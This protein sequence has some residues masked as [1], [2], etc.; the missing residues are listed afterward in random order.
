LAWVAA[1]LALRTKSGGRLALVAVGALA[2]WLAP[3]ALGRD[4]P[5]PERP[6][7]A[8][9][10]AAGPPR[11]GSF[12]WSL[13]VRIES[14]R[15]GGRLALLA[16]PAFVSLPAAPE[17]GQRFHLTGYLG[18]AP[19]VYND[20]SAELGPWRLRVKSAHFV[21]PLPAGWRGEWRGISRRLQ[22]KVGQVLGGVEGG[23][24]GALARAL[25]LGEAEALP[26]RVRRALRRFGVAH[27]VAVS[28]LHVTLLA[29]AAA[30]A[31]RLLPRPLG[32]TLPLAACLGYLAL[33]GPRPS[34]VRASAMVLI[35][36]AAIRSGRPPQSLHALGTVAVLLCLLDPRGLSDLGL[37]LTLAATAGILL[38]GLWL[39]SNRCLGRSVLGR[40]VVASLAAQIATWPFALPAFHLIAPISPVANL[41]A[42]PWAGV[43]LVLAVARCAGR[44]A[45]AVLDA[46]LGWALEAAASPFW[47]LAGLPAQLA[48]VRPV[49]CGPL[50]ATALA[51]VAVAAL[52][53]PRWAMAGATWWLVATLSRPAVPANPELRL[54]DVGQGEAILLT[55]RGRAVLIDGGGWAGGD[56]AAELLLPALARAGVRELAAIILTHPDLDHCAGLQGLV[57]Y[58]PVAEL[59]TPPGWPGRGCALELL[60]A[61]G[62]RLRPLWAGERFAVGRWEF[63]ALHPRAGARHGGNDRSLVLR[64][65]A[66]GVRVLLTGDVEA[67]AERAILA[68]EGREGVRCEV[69]KLAHHGSA[70]STSAP[71]LEAAAPRLAVASAGAGNRYGHPAARVRGRLAAAGIPLLSTD[72]HGQIRLRVVRPGGFSLVA[73]EG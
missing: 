6:V 50:A 63:E 13:P 27:L 53:Y 4:F 22:S 5:D 33:I 64:A 47:W 17:G 40:A 36:A 65:E 34:L 15:Q 28:G 72:R 2:V 48:F 23:R 57:D 49:G 31:G 54:L 55:D 56:P 42:V 8:I 18:R 43:V 71:F 29:G 30:L 11:A 12:G 3:P 25:L 38:S 58:L 20:A 41:V 39:G 73:G 60:S 52:R 45:G 14:L 32:R 69:L 68:R 62:P 9:A 19:G 35:A 24:G 67:E 37:Q 61:P 26:P 16:E 51:L 66:M 1:A 70:T 59:W 44:V 7:R 10:R 46:P 21:E